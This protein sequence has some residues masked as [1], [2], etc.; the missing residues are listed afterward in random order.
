MT[1]LKRWIA[2][3]GLWLI[4][5]AGGSLIAADGNVVISQLYGG[6]GS[7]SSSFYESDY[8][9]LF[10]PG[11]NAV[12]LNGWSVQ[13]AS[14]S[15]TTWQ[16]TPLTNSVAARGYYLVRQSTGASGLPIPTAQ[17]TGTVT[18][19]ATAG[20]VALVNVT[21]GLSG[22]NPVGSNTVV[23]FV[24]YGLA[25]AYE[26]SGAAG[27]PAT[28]L[29]VVRIFQG[30]HDTDDNAIDFEVVTPAPRNSASPLATGVVAVAS[31]EFPT[32]LTGTGAVLNASVT[33][34][35]IETAVW[36]EWGGGRLFNQSTVVTN[37]TSGSNSLGVAF[38]ISNL[39]AGRVY[40]CR[41]VASNFM[42][43]VLGREQRVWVP[44][45]TL[46]GDAVITNVVDQAW[47]D[48]G[49]VVR[50]SPLEIAAAGSHS[51]ALRADGR[52]VV[53]GNNVSGQTN[54]PPG[55]TNAVGVGAG[56]GHSLAV[57]PDD[58]VV[59]WGLNNGGQT[60]VPSGLSNAVWAGGGTDHSVA[61]R[62]DGVPVAWGTNSVGQTNV[63]GTIT[64]A[65]ALAAGNQFTVALQAG[66]GV[67]GW[68]FNPSALTIPAG[69]S[70]GVIAVGTGFDHALAVRGDGTVVA[71]GLNASGQ[72]NVP[73]GLTNA[74]WVDGGFFHSVALR[75]DGVP[76]AWGTN[77]SGQLNVPAGLTNAVDVAAG[78]NFTIALRAD[79]TITGWGVNTSGQTSVP[80]GLT[81]LSLP[82]G[83]SG[84]V[85]TNVPGTYVLTYTVT[86][87]LGA[88]VTAQRTVVVAAAPA[89][90]TGIPPT[91]VTGSN[92]TMNGEVN[93]NGKP[94]LAWFEWGV[95]QVFSYA[96]APTNL[97][98]GSGEVAFSALLT[99]LVAGRAYHFRVVASNALG[100]VRGPDVRVWA[101][102]LALNGAPVI[103]NSAGTAWV[104]PGAVVS[105]SPMQVAAG[106][107]HSLALR[108]DGVPVA[109]GSNSSGKTNVPVGLTGVVHVAGGVSHS[110]AVR[111]DGTVVAWG[112]NTSG[113]TNVP[114]GLVDAVSASGGSS[115]SLVLRSNGVPLAW[116][117]SASGQTNVPA[118]IQ[119]ATAVAAGD[120][121]GLA[122]LAEGR[123]QGWGFS[124]DLPPI[125]R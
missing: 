13:Y 87:S 105:A 47:V 84:T 65:L 56:G 26:G 106:G 49:A 74:V 40:A 98:S 43:V 71:W 52:V 110:L 102:V 117:S 34:Y 38:G 27:T 85:N 33:T 20:K 36:M 82:V 103:T 32:G 101:P 17:T 119:T 51:M 5:G 61:L 112:A 107:S 80:A 63:P 30:F 79:G 86:N 99:N 114:A 3:L 91:G 55:L 125:K 62:A 39:V 111:G 72:T 67:T 48:P 2:W 77:S 37:V 18:M 14:S 70:N 21:N 41:V 15:G 68:G 76:V 113:A 19:N 24:G 75:A 42:G 121:H 97:G 29:A 83:I 4:A 118:D 66:G 100:V 11:T 95:G 10:N 123:V 9:E 78:N 64:N 60:N 108:A 44:V 6:G 57:T 69:A 104:D 90:A 25:N 31:T 8:V 122:L 124:G 93:P 16:R 73:P 7:A 28:N 96:T 88:V 109:W 12:S 92:A 23:D 54:V 53:W 58:R 46:T 81:N 94:T 59:A 115:L 45:L 120:S 89:I 1:A 22:F 50:A 35:G 116:G